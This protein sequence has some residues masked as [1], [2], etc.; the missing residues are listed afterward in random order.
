MS[1]VVLLSTQRSGTNLL[2]SV[3]DSHPQVYGAL[4]EI[5]HSNHLADPLRFF[6]F[7]LE[8]VKTDPALALPGS[9]IM[10][11][12]K[13]LEFLDRKLP[14]QITILDV[15][16][17]SLHHLDEWWKG[18]DGLFDVC[19][20][21][22][23]PV[24]HLIRNNVVRTAVSELIANQSR[25]FVVQKGAENAPL[26]KLRIEPRA[27]LNRIRNLQ[28][29]IEMHRKRYSELAGYIEVH[30]EDLTDP[31]GATIN[32]KT[33]EGLAEFLGVEPTFEKEPR[34]RKI[35]RGSLRETLANFDEL[36]AALEEQDLALE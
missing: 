10:E 23:I 25:V 28:R 9:R 30:Y 19:K 24:I 12:E 4:G 2:R 22:N 5:F 7:L 29:T 27:L 8:E 6:S 15:K 21:L 32:E 17:N 1:S 35:L 18:K 3:L 13:Y 34:T 14:D 20:R 31:N 36:A 33:F 16:Y 11:F 26:E